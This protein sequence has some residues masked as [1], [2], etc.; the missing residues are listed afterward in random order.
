M[1]RTRVYRRM[2]KDFET[3]V[4]ELL[5]FIRQPSVSPQNFGVGEAAGLLREMASR[6][7]FK[8]TRLVETSGNPVVYGELNVGAPLTVLVYTMY[9][10][11]P[12]DENG[13]VVNPFAGETRR[14]EPFWETLIARGA[15]N[16]KGP[17]VAFLNTVRAILESDQEPPVNLIFAA[18]GEEELGSKHLP[19]FIGKYESHL[20]KAN[21]L[22]FPSASQNSRGKAVVTLSVK[23]IVYF[24]LELD[25]K[26]WGKGPTEFGIHGNKAWVDSP[27]WRMVEAL[28]TMVDETGNRVLIEGFYD[29]VKVPTQEDEALLTMFAE[30]FDEE[31]V[32]ERMKV[33]RF[34]DDLHGVEALRKYLFSPG[35]SDA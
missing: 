25:G 11:M 17:L 33:E 30:T 23:G 32:K 14:V 8:N 12:A 1:D 29:D 10:T 6:A 24:E 5:T 3:H 34:I 9:D 7:G 27:A 21:V 2:E 16:T 35:S 22:F 19:E 31:E 20:R 26:E 4:G 28:S 13:W 15:V 18:E